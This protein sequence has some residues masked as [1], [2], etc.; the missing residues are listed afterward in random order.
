MKKLISLVLSL[1]L[2]MPLTGRVVADFAVSYSLSDITNILKYIA[3]WG[4]EYYRASYDYNGDVRIN[5]YDVTCILKDIAGWNKENICLQRPSE[6]LIQQ[7]NNDI[8]DYLVDNYGYPPEIIYSRMYE[9]HGTYNGA[10]VFMPLEGA[11]DAMRSEYIDG[12]EISY[13]DTNRLIVWK[14]GDFFHLSGAYNEGILT[15]DDVK[16][17]ANIQNHCMAL[18]L[19]FQLS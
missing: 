5:I 4:D 3:E 19:V 15:K 10:V 1:I 13:R 11:G 8:I 16:E 6:E 12:I 9:Y 7:I 18:N 17:V 14:D 2:M